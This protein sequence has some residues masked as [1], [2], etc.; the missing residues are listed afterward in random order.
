MESNDLIYVPTADVAELQKFLTIV[1]SA[2]QF[3]YDAAVSK[4]LGL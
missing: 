1:N 4:S 3:F 2:A